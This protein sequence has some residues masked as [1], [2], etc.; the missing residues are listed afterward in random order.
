MRKLKSYLLVFCGVVMVSCSSS[1]TEPESSLISENTTSADKHKTASSNKE[2]TTAIS[3]WET[4]IRSSPIKEKAKWISSIKFGEEVTIIGDSTLTEGN[5][6]KTYLHIKLSDGKTGWDNSYLYAQDAVRGV[7][8]SKLQL[9]DRPDI[10]AM[11]KESIA[12]GQIVAIFNEGQ[13]DW[14]EVVGY[15]KKKKGWV[16]ASEGLST[17]DI[18]IKVSALM[19][20]LEKTSDDIEREILISQLLDDPK[21]ETSVLYDV[22]LSKYRPEATANNDTTVIR[23]EEEEYID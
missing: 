18:D 20:L 6:D 17:R 2:T 10:L 23:F 13:D 11:A 3:L 8:V 7:V 12:E 9:Y 16:N 5:K 1:H 19:A 14:K 22:F 21:N 15:N 4:G